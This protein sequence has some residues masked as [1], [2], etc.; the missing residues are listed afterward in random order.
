MA[1]NCDGSAV[2]SYG[3]KLQVKA[4]EAATE[5]MDV[6]GITGFNGPQTS[7]GEIDTTTLCSKAKE[8]ALDLKDNGTF[9][10]DMQTR[11]GDPAQQL[12]IEGLD[13]PNAYY[14]R[15]VL[16]DDGYG[17][18]EVTIDFAARVQSFPIQGAM[19][20]VITTSLSLRITGDVT[21][22]YPDDSSGG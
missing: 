7:R 18:G 21:I 8:Y 4:T 12:L 17:G 13:S 14:F 15:L 5:Y 19:G 16:P 20:Q 9:T 22:T 3:A 2:V 6:G 11:L 10:A 1:N